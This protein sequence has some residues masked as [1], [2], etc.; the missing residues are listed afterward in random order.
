MDSDYPYPVNLG[1]PEELKIIEIA[2]IIKS[3]INPNLE[4]CYKELPQDDPLQRKPII[5]LAKEKLNWTP[6]ISFI[7]G[8]DKTINYFREN[9]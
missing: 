9:I 4:I 7:D 6:K 2:E 8:I 3:K 5:Q 1:N